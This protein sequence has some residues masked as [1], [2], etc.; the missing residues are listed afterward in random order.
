VA[1]YCGCLRVMMLLP[2]YELSLCHNMSV[3]YWLPR[4]GFYSLYFYEGEWSGVVTSIGLEEFGVVEL[5][6]RLRDVV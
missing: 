4:C 3:A 2:F 5:V 6:P 1:N